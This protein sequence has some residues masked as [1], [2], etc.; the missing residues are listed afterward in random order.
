VKRIFTPLDLKNDPPG[1]GDH[2]I[3]VTQGMSGYFAVEMW[4]NAEQ[5]SLFDGKPLGP[6]PEP[7]DTGVGRY[8]T[9][10]EACVEAWH[11]AE[12]QGLP[13]RLSYTPGMPEFD[14]ARK[15]MIQRG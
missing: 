2:W 8:R 12:S 1:P 7:W 11:L 13:Y 3:E 9:E 15:A 4:I 10:A 14:T 5:E 6:F